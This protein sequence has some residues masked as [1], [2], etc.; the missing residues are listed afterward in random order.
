[1][2]I[3]GLTGTIGSWKGTVVEY[4]KTQ[5]FHHYSARDVIIEEL[6]RQGLEH[7]RDEMARIANAMRQK[8]GPAAIIQALYHKAKHHGWNAV[9]ESIRTLGEIDFLRDQP[10]FFLW[11]VDADQKVR[12]QRIVERNLSTD[13]INFETFVEQ[14]RTELH[15]N[16]PHKQNLLACIDRADKIFHNTHTIETLYT[17]V[18]Q[19]LQELL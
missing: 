16:D 4:L 8:D 13:K 18:N 3:I 15:G 7:T 9:I 2:L 11:A 19:V 6:D 14:E 12:Y 17:E 1:M 5:G 10:H